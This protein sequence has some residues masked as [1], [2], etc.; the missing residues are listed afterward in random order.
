MNFSH[1]SRG[2]VV[3]TQ[4]LSEALEGSQLVRAALDVFEEE[5]LPAKSPLR[6]NSKVLLTDHMAWYSEQS[7]FQLQTS[8]ARVIVTVCTGGLPVRWG[9]RKSSNAWSD[10]MSGFLGVHALATCSQ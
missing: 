2:P 7:G 4:A 10:S 9:I 6:C 5:S 3:D 1:T 8:A